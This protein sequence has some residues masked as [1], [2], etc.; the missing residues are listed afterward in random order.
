[1]EF[2]VVTYGILD[3]L[4]EGK[5]KYITHGIAHDCAVNNMCNRAKLHSPNIL[6]LLAFVWVLSLFLQLYLK[7]QYLL[8]L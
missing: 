1:M 4:L 7:K 2:L 3:L 5:S 6:L 8:T